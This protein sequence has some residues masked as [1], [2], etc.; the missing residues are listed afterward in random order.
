MSYVNQWQQFFDGHAPLYMENSF[1]RHTVAEVDFL[2][3]LTELPPG[4]SIL[5][6][7]CGTGRHSVELARRGYRVTGVDLSKGML[8]Q[9]REAAA[10]AG[11][12]VRWVHADATLY[13]PRGRFD[14]AIC[15]CEGAFSLLGQSDDPLEHDRAILRNIHAALAVGA[16][17]V[18]TAPNALKH[19]RHYNQRDV[20][21]GKFDPLTLV[22]TFTLEWDAPSGK[23][24]VTVRCKNYV[25]SELVMVLRQEGFQVKHVWGGTAGH[26]GRRMVDLD[27][28]EV[29]VVARKAGG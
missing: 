8:A 15:L 25:P 7:G 29:M 28:M 10:W 22:E 12:Q 17:L 23:A 3:E 20:E 27:E 26:W 9:A 14:A 5:D 18:L 24:S 1:T 19:I 16:P 2:L 6:V 21:V 4:S 11:V 13:R